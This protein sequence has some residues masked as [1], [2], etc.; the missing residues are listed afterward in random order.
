MFQG[1]LT[2][3]LSNQ[4]EESINFYSIMVPV[5]KK[6]IRVWYSKAQLQG[7]KFKPPGPEVTG[8]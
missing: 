4:G 2:G 8:P 7:F 1:L 3:L 5:I 6:S